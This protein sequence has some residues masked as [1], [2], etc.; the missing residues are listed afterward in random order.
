[1]I[2]NI[3][4]STLLSLRAHKLRVFLTMVG[5]IIGIASVVT[6]SALGEGVRHESMQL[7]D[8]TEANVITIQ[9]MMNMTD[10]SGMSYVED[11]FSFNK[12]DMRRLSR[13]EGVQSVTPNYGSYG[14][15]GDTI[16]MNI[17]Y[18][19]AQAYTMATPH[20]KESPILYGRDLRNDDANKDVIVL[21]HDVIDYGISV[22]D[23]ETLVGQAVNINGYMF[24]VIGIKEPY[25]WEDEIISTSSYSWEDAMTSVVPQAAYNNLTRSKAIQSLKVKVADGYNRE[26]VSMELMNNLM[27]SYP[28]DEGTF[29][30]D[31]S[32]EQMME[33]VNNYINGIMTFLIAITAISLF[34]GGI[35]VMNIMYVSVTERKREIGIRRAIGA[36][37]RMILLQFLLEAAFITF[38]GGMIG[39]LL[40]YGIATL[41]GMIISLPVY[42]TPTIMIL[43]T[44][45][46][47]GTGLI[48]GIIPALSASKMDP[49]K[50]IYQ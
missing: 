12:A 16:D 39:L 34:V 48:F 37:P 28:E 46:S 32:N 3:M 21:S 9:H 8:T 35:G 27:E 22:E 18:F 6:I 24:E 43:S 11:T 2:R 50:A 13:V 42:L 20:K 4:M 29:E 31:R 17:D 15:A 49:I 30:E 10:D 1:M 44:S 40:G 41:I 7:A 33:E 5:I 36:K 25:V 47:I 38:L 19:G 23:P 14:M 45:V 26:L